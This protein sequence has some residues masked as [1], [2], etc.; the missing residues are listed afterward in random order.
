MNL[1]KVSDDLT[2]L[3]S[4][5]AYVYLHSR[6]TIFSQLKKYVSHC[7]QQHGSFTIPLF[8]DIKD[9]VC[10]DNTLYKKS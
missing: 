7:G 5:A 9:M 2:C 1:S 3:M 8:A 6:V 10:P 4:G